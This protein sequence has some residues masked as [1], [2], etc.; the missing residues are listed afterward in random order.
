MSKRKI[1]TIPPIL[2][3]GGAQQKS[4]PKAEVNEVALKKLVRSEVRRSVEYSVESYRSGPL[5]SP[6]ET[7]H[8]ERIFPGFTEKWSGMAAD[9]QHER[10]AVIKRRDGYEFAYKI[11]ALVAAVAITLV[12]IIGGLLLIWN[13]KNSEG[14]TTLGAGV[15]AILAALVFRG[16]SK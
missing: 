5:P 1:K 9:E 14:F 8:Y 4:A 12:F 15:A 16:K 7:E 11:A 3:T 10:F 6:E 2:R 13:G